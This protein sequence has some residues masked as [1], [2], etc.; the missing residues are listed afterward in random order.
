MANTDT[1]ERFM[2]AALKEAEKGLGRT[3]PNPAVGAVLVVNN[4]IVARGHHRGAGQPHAEVE[5]LTAWGEPLPPDAILFVT[6]E[7][8]STVGRTAA[9]TDVIIAAGVKNVVIGTIDVKR[10]Y[11][12]HPTPSTLGL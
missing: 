11:D 2:R 10:G 4:R 8:C 5:C 9:C 7:P 6:L 12:G 1:D 3:S